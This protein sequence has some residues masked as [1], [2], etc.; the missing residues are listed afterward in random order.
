MRVVR[1]KRFRNDEDTAHQRA[2]AYISVP[3]KQ[4][5]ARMS[6][7]VDVDAIQH[8]ESD[9]QRILRL[10]G[11]I[12]TDPADLTILVI[13]GQPKSK[14]RARFG[15]GGHVYTPEEQ[16]GAEELLGWR[17]KQTFREP[18]TG[19]L[20][21]ACLFFRKS[22]HRVDVDNMLKHVMDAA[23][24]ICW[25]D[26][27]QVTAMLGIAEVDAARPRLV[28]AIGPHQSSMDRGAIPQEKC[29]ACGAVFTPTNRANPRRFCSRTCASRSRPRATYGNC[30]DCGKEI[31]P[32]ARHAGLRCREC[33]LT[34][35]KPNVRT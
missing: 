9:Q 12:V 21:V 14:S 5:A 33:W 24:G 27:Y 7:L 10:L 29:E 6:A 1:E 25:T 15:C 22:H 2:N 4:A 17:L 16:R 31:R 13:D 32:K 11:A 30:I 19:N 28:L 26:D 8:P 34:S 3:S 35:D 23:N 20:A 18:M